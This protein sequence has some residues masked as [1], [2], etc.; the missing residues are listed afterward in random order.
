MKKH[1]PVMTVY[2]SEQQNYFKRDI[3]NALI[4]LKLPY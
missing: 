2:E 4:N 3:S 1:K